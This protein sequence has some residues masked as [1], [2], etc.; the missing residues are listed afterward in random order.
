MCDLQSLNGH[1]I[2]VFVQT[3]DF[4][5]ILCHLV[6]VPRPSL[7]PRVSVLHAGRWVPRFSPL[8]YTPLWPRWP[9]QV[10]QVCMVVWAAACV[11]SQNNFKLHCAEDASPLP[12][13]VCPSIPLSAQIEATTKQGCR[14]WAGVP[15][16]TVSHGCSAHVSPLLSGSSA[17]V[18]A[19][20][21]A[22]SGQGCC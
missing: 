9:R 21:R 5:E 10:N 18:A 6:Q 13:L 2:L 22:R 7:T 14:P 16:E 1:W 8:Y 4:L 3:L 20:S 17:K 11:E 19:G 12:P 15:F